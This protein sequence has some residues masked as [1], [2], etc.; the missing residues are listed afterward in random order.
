MRAIRALVQRLRRSERGAAAVEF[1]LV[2]PVM[3]ALYLG[4]MEASLLIS[5]DRKVQSV[6]GAVGDLVARSNGEIATSTLRDYFRAASGIMTPFTSDEVLQV[7]TA[8]RVSNTGTP[9][10]AWSRQ[11][12]NG[13]LSATTPYTA[14]A[15][16]PLPQAMVDI[17]RG[18]MVI[19]AEASQSY[20]PLYGMVF[21]QAVNLYRSS[22]FMP[23]FGDDIAPPN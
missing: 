11:Y 12:I 10:V 8:V 14:G 1:A 21:N 19:A 20:K 22:F 16:Y 9:T 2:V 17:S 13:V 18:R 23:R 4:T 3:L 15:R 6:S 5:M 7:V